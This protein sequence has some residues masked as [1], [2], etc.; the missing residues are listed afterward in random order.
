[1]HTVLSA[2]TKFYCWIGQVTGLYVSFP[3]CLTLFICSPSIWNCF[4]NYI[5]QTCCSSLERYL[6]TCKVKIT[7][8]GKTGKFGW[9]LWGFLW[10]CKQKWWACITLESR[11][12]RSKHKS[13]LEHLEKH[14][15]VNRRRDYL[16]TFGW[17]I[18]NPC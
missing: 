5:F 7:N 11:K 15:G 17:L 12:I 3:S 1:M 8:T 18:W 16:S 9:L 2:Q 10:L 14:W 13:S 6:E 4:M